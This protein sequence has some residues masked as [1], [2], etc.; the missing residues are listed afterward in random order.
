MMATTTSDHAW[1]FELRLC[2]ATMSSHVQ[3][4]V[5]VIERIP[6]YHRWSLVTGQSG[7]RGLCPIKEQRCEIIVTFFDAGLTRKKREFGK[8]DSKRT[9]GRGIV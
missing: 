8:T 9:R 5:G 4:R 2:Y 3:P 1:A 6:R 7:K